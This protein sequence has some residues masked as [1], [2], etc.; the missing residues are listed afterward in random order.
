M[1]E[2][3]KR[4]S[5]QDTVTLKPEVIDWL[6]E[7]I[8][9]KIDTD[10]NTPVNE[11][12]GWCIGNDEYNSHKSYEINVLFARQ[13]D[14]LKF[15]DKWSIYKKPTFY[16]DYFNEDRREMNIKE[17][18][19]ILNQYRKDNDLGLIDFG[20]KINIPHKRSTD[21]NQDTFQL[22]DWDNLEEE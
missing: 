14:A 10:E 22:I 20:D 11:R 15:I 8:Q 1:T 3:Y 17:I 5:N 7:N 12:K 18:L 19:S 21:L 6:N 13:K 4:I 9:D 2:H 16:F